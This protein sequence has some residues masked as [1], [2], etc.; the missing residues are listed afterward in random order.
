[1]TGRLFA[2]LRGLWLQLRRRSKYAEVRR[3]ASMDEVPDVLSS[4][5]YLVVRGGSPRWAVMSCPCRC[6]ARIEV[7]LMRSQ[8]PYWQISEEANTITLRPSLWRSNGTCMSHFFVE[9]NNVRWV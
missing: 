4:A 5:I 7:N 3:V 1:M 9:R 6:G 8:H 2:W